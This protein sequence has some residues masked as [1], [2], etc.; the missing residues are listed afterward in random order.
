MLRVEALSKSYGETTLF[1][2]LSFRLNKGER[3]A[4]VGRNGCG[5]STLLKILIGSETADMGQIELPKHYRI[6]YLEQHIAFTQKTLR[7]EASLALPEEERALPYKVEAILCGLGFKIEDLDKDPNQFSGGYQLRIQLAKTLAKE[8]DCLLLDEPTNYLDII[9]IRWLEKFLKSWKGEMILISHDRSFLDAVATHTMGIH[10]SMLLRIEGKTEQYYNHL[11]QIEEIHE[12]TRLKIEKQKESA[13]NFIRRFGSKATKARQAQS[14][15]KAIER[16]PSL[17]KLAHI[18]GLDFEFN[19]A[20]FSARR[21]LR[22]QEIS[23]QY[24]QMEEAL[25]KGISFEIEKGERIGIIGK[26]GRGKSTLLRL[27]AGELEPSKGKISFAENLSVGFFGQTNIQKLKSDL[28]IEEEIRASNSTLSYSEVR[29]ICGAM[30]FS[31]KAAEKKISMLSGGE[32]SRVLL[33]KIL[34]SPCNLLLLDEPSN[35]LD[36]E[37]VEA[38]IEALE[39]FEG[40]VIIVS[41]EEEILRRTVDKLFICKE[42]TQKLFDGDYDEFLEKVGYEDEVP[43]KKKEIKEIV[44][45]KPKINSVLKKQIEKIEN[46]IMELEAELASQLME[47]EAASAK[48]DRVHLTKISEKVGTMQQECDALYTELEKKHDEQDGKRREE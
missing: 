6:G 19:A 10:R 4:L 42:N 15:R 20:P 39:H 21:M 36:I 13:E 33:G 12:K 22:A 32:R 14:R 5:K 43:K 24:P 26:N 27:L 41:H 37:S 7:E 25:I 35:H 18:E 44:E 30:L 29:K 40:S 23:F 11:V 3:C 2:N 8:P 17:E 46:R 38:L 45:K 1:E 28:S 47:L 9:S 31:G 34:A 48:N 16:L